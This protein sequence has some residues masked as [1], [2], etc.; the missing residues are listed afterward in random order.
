M[1]NAERIKL[2]TEQAD[3]LHREA[4]NLTSLAQTASISGQLNLHPAG[5]R[6]IAQH[7]GNR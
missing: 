4:E 6:T 3:F 5:L 1:K 7:T 2:L